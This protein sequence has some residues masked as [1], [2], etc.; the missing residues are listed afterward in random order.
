LKYYV[1][2]CDSFKIHFLA[3]L[4]PNMTVY[5]IHL[6]VVRRSKNTVT[7]LS[8]NNRCIFQRSVYILLTTYQFIFLRQIRLLQIGK[9]SF[10]EQIIHEHMHCSHHRVYWPVLLVSFT[11]TL[12]EEFCLYAPYSVIF[13][14]FFLLRFLR[15]MCVIKSIRL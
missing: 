4:L 3:A 12:A 10:S 13:R 5:W 1:N 7:T 14:S 9:S 2:I 6:S 8:V 15:C 11:S